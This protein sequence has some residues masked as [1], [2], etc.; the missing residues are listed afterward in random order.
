MPEQIDDSSVKSTVDGREKKNT[1]RAGSKSHA[2]RSIFMCCF[3]YILLERAYSLS[4]RCACSLACA[5]NLKK[6]LEQNNAI[7]NKSK[8]IYTEEEEK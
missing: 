8:Y 2:T 1:G 3:Y 7:S 5:L 4:L 6:L